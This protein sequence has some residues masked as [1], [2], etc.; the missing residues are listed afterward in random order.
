MQKGLV[1]AAEGLLALAP[2][3]S[4]VLEP[5]LPANQVIIGGEAEVRQET[6]ENYKFSKR[7]ALYI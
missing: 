2:L 6:E 7:W 1:V 4:P 5:H 3:R